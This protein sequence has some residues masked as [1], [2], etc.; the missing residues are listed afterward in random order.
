MVFLHDIIKG[1]PWTEVLELAKKDTTGRVR[2]HL[3]TCQECIDRGTAVVA[4]EMAALPENRRNT[5]LRIGHQI[6][7]LYKRKKTLPC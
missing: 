4:G 6:S 2:T 5:I 7:A 1:M 3:D